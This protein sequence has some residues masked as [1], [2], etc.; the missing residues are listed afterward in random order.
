MVFNT[1]IVN[2]TNNQE[3]QKMILYGA[4]NEDGVFSQ[5]DV[6]EMKEF[7]ERFTAIQQPPPTT[8]AMPKCADWE[9]HRAF[10]LDEITSK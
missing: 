5:Q 8:P 9:Y 4:Q 3:G 1:T 2:A 6:C 7:Y 10:T